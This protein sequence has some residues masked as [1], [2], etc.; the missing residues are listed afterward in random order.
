MA[1][2]N[3]RY[4]RP[5]DAEHSYSEGRNYGRVF[6]TVRR[7]IAC[8]SGESAC[9]PASIPTDHPCPDWRQFL[10][11]CWGRQEGG[12]C[13]VN[14]F[15]QVEALRTDVRLLETRF[16]AAQE[17]LLVLGGRRLRM[18]LFPARK[19]TPWAREQRPPSATCKIYLWDA[20]QTTFL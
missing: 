6:R 18:A 3:G 8:A 9:V 11:G 2:R 19:I 13:C 7:K 5:P 1:C 17:Q 10:R 14:H 16:V 15:Q 4:F 12:R 20:G